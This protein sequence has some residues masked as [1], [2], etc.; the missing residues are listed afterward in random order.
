MIQSTTK[1]LHINP[2]DIIVK[3]GSYIY[4]QPCYKIPLALS[5]V[6]CRTMQSPNCVPYNRLLLLITYFVQMI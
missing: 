3:D 5:H 1:G 6:E 2:V 4:G